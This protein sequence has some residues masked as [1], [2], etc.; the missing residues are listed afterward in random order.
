[1]TNPTNDQLDRHIAERVMGYAVHE[2]RKD[3]GWAAAIADIEPD[4]YPLIV[5]AESTIM[6]RLWCSAMSG[7]ILVPLHQ[8]RGCVGSDGRI[9]E[10]SANAILHN[11]PARRR[12]VGVYAVGER[13]G[14]LGNFGRHPARAIALALYRATGDSTMTDYR[15]TH[16][17]REAAKAICEQFF[18]VLGNDDGRTNS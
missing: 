16:A 6:Q 12:V 9:L 1:M 10:N 4:D 17:D 8:H 5:L 2:Y 13:P 11:P 15:P 7:R 3:E 18:I 14:P